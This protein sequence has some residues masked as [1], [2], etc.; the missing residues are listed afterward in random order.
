MKGEIETEDHLRM[1]CEYHREVNACMV[2][3]RAVLLLFEELDMLRSAYRRVCD[4]IWKLTDEQIG[5]LIQPPESPKPPDNRDPK[6]V[7]NW[8]DCREGAYHPSCCRFPKSCSCG[9]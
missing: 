5:N 1:L 3:P 2:D 7:E 9:R 8:P 4:L 6:C